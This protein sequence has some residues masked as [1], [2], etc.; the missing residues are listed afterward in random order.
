METVLAG[1]TVPLKVEIK[2][3]C[4]SSHRGWHA[5]ELAKG[6]VSDGHHALR[7]RLR[8]VPPKF[9]N[10]PVIDSPLPSGMQVQATSKTRAPAA[11]CLLRPPAG[12]IM[13]CPGRLVLGRP[14]ILAILSGC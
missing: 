3:K 12:S 6:V 5:P 11:K 1:L 10:L 13:R 14:P 4:R 8:D 9:A 2:N 7:Q